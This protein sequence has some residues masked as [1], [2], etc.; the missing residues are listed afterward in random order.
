VVRINGTEYHEHGE[1]VYGVQNWSPM[2]PES[3]PGLFYDP[4]TGKMSTQKEI[5]ARIKWPKMGGI[6]YTYRPRRRR[7]WGGMEYPLVEGPFGPKW[8]YGAEDNNLKEPQELQYMRK[9]LDAQIVIA[10][11][12]SATAILTLWLIF[13]R[14]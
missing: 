13:G 14:K 3:Y 8:G 12:S 1:K 11:A 5:M 7:G 2:I 10:L 9:M 4:T 6:P